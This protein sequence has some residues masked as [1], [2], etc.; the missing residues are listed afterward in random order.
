MNIDQIRAGMPALTEILQVNSGTKGICAAPVVEALLEN[1]R[2]VEVG[3]YLGY[4]EIQ[5][6][7]ATARARLAGVFGCD[8]SELAFTGNAT[9]SLNVALAL[10]WEHWGAGGPVDVL[11]SD[12][13]YPTTN[14]VFGY[15]EKIGKARLIRFVLSEDFETMQESL[16][17]Q[18]TAGTKLLVGSH[19]CCNTGLRTDA[20][21][22]SDWARAR[23]IVSYI[24]GAQAAGQFPINLHALGCDLYITN[25][26]KWLFGPNGVGLLYVR[27]GFED[28]LTPTMVGMGT[29]DFSNHG[30]WAPGAQ[31]FDLAA[32][33]PAQVLATMH[34][35]LDWLEGLGFENLWARQK[36]LT[37]HVKG[38]I[39]EMPE[40]FTLLTPLEFEKSSALTSIQIA[41]KTGEQIGAFAGK[42]LEEKR[43][44]L[45]PVPEFDALRL[46]MAYY[47]TEEDFE[48]AFAMLAEL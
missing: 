6:K 27:A 25:G 17:A 41:G 7:A 5:Q 20:K 44:F 38:R 26:H 23:G 11:I 28:E 2:R 30:S 43:A 22:L 16:E 35:A 39:L 8:D 48:R 24:D 3:G 42:M 12:H 47:N 4:C 21:A 19:V 34:A 14:M 37:D 9:V 15:L 13:E 31:R 45:R 40:R 46:S 32:T 36:A 33:R 1:T 10:P 18:V 29:M